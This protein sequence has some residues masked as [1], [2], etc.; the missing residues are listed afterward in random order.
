ML[1]VFSSSIKHSIRILLQL[2]LILTCYKKEGVQ[3]VIS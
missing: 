3:K 2:Y 1:K